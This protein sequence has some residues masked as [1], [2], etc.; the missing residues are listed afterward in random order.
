MFDG[1]KCYVDQIVA[2][3]RPQK[4]VYLAMDGVP[5]MAKLKE[6]AKRRER[7]FGSSSMNPHMLT[8]G[9]EFMGN[10]S[11]ALQQYCGNMAKRLRVTVHFDLWS[12]PGEGEHKIIKN[13][14]EIRSDASGGIV[15]F[16]ADADLIVT[17][18]P[19]KEPKIGLVREN[20]ISRKRQYRQ[21]Q[22]EELSIPKL[23]KAF[24]S[25]YAVC[26]R[27]MKIEL[28]DF[29][30][31]CTILGND[32]IGTP[33]G[34]S[35]SFDLTRILNFIKQ[36]SS[37]KPESSDAGS[38]AGIL[39]DHTELRQLVQ[40]MADFEFETFQKATG[41]SQEE[42]K[43]Q[44]LEL[45][46]NGLSLSEKR[47]SIENHINVIEKKRF[48]D[49]RSRHYKTMYNTNHFDF[50]DVTEKYFEGLRLLD[51]Y[52]KGEDCIDSWIFPYE[53]VPMFSDM[54][55]HC[56]DTPITGAGEDID[57]RPLH[58]LALVTPARSKSLLP[59]VYQMD[60]RVMG[61]DI[62]AMT[63]E[64][65]R[66]LVSYLKTD[67]DPQLSSNEQIRN[68]NYSSYSTFYPDH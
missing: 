34:L 9:T 48:E 17:C 11:S 19:M 45:S 12:R 27:S 54:L 31:A 56:T 58:Q 49:W 29:A 42:K 8:P 7:S 50:K 39:Y 60:E 35:V 3:T 67:L 68:T 1:I 38:D 57:L 53:F 16:T 30:F 40:L 24:L 44:I 61:A 37:S 63:L 13:I 26:G 18:I 65:L 59:D 55:N 28:Y 66:E 41:L 32:F 14:N 2:T 6:Q 33:D 22:F 47:S 10:L 46:M 51:R 15:I 36:V 23:Q 52:Y 62:S 64:D 4:V 43:D 20:Y 5:P 21:K 25:Q